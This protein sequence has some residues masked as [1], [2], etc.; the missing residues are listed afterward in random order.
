MPRSFSFGV[1]VWLSCTAQQYICVRC[2]GKGLFCRA[3]KQLLCNQKSSKGMPPDSRL[4]L[5][6]GLRVLLMF[7]KQFLRPPD[8]LL[9]GWRVYAGGVV[10]LGAFKTR[11]EN[12]L[13]CS[14]AR[15]TDRPS[16]VLDRHAAMR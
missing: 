1:G 5:C 10:C 2:S 12:P 6:Y 14:R 13:P 11:F 4:G 8:G 7:R 3:P 15:P 9:G 16:R